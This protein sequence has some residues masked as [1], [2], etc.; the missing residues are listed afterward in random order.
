MK[1]KWMICMAIVTTA[2]VV[3]SAV[4]LAVAQEN[5]STH[6]DEVIATL[7]NC[8][9][10]NR[11]LSVLFLLDE[12]QSL[13]GF[14]RV[15]GTDEGHIRV[16]GVA[17]ALRGLS[18]LQTSLASSEGTGSQ[19]LQISIRIDGFGENYS[20][21]TGGEWEKLS[22][23]SLPALI[24]A[25]EG[26]T[27]RT[28]EI[29]T[30]Y[31]EAMSGAAAAFSQQRGTCKLLLWFTDGIYDSDNSP[32]GTITEAERTEIETTLCNPGGMV[33]SLRSQDVIILALA[34]S[35]GDRAIDTSLVEVMAEGGTRGGYSC[36]ESNQN[37]IFNVASKAEDL[38]NG[39]AGLLTNTVFEAEYEPKTHK[40][41]GCQKEG[42]GVS[43]CVFEFQLGPWT[44]SF[45]LYLEVP[46]DPEFVVIIRQPDGI[47]IPVA[48]LISSPGLSFT[49]PST[50]WRL[51]RGNADRGGQWS[52]WWGLIL[53][54][55][56]SEE[57][58]GHI[59][60][61]YDEIVV[62]SDSSVRLQQFEQETFAA[63]SLLVEIGELP[64]SEATLSEK[65]NIVL[66]VVALPNGPREVLEIADGNEVQPFLPEEF[67]KKVFQLADGPMATLN[68]EVTPK[69]IVGKNGGGFGIEHSYEASFVQFWLYDQIVVELD[70]ASH[71]L[72]KED[73]E[74]LKGVEVSL[75]VGEQSFDYKDA[76][77]SLEFASIGQSGEASQSTTVIVENG[78]L[79]E[80][81]PAFLKKVIAVDGL[82]QLELEVTPTL[83][84]DGASEGADFIELPSS[85]IQIGVRTGPGY[86]V[87]Q[88]VTATDIDQDSS[89]TL[90]VW[91]EGPLDGT[92][93]LEILGI[94]TPDGLGG[95]FFLDSDEI[96]E[97][98]E[99]QV[100]VCDA[101]ISANFETTQEI[102]LLVSLELHGNRA[103][104][105][106]LP[107]E[108]IAVFDMTK[109]INIPV[110]IWKF[111]IFFAIFVLVQLL[112]AAF[113]AKKISHWS[114]MP[115]LSRW[116]SIPVRV[117]AD[118]MVLGRQG[119]RL[120]IP[121]DQAR[122]ANEFEVPNS[123]AEVA[124]V[125][126]RISWWETFIGKNG[127]GLLGI[128]REIITVSAPGSHCFGP[129][130]L[131]FVCPSGVGLIGNSLIQSWAL[132][133][134]HDDLS[135]VGQG[136]SIN[137]DL[138]LLL[139]DH[140]IK[141]FDIQLEEINSKMTIVVEREIPILIEA[142]ANRK[143]LE[144]DEASSEISASSNEDGIGNS[145][146]DAAESNV[147]K[148]DEEPASHRFDSW[149]LSPEDPLD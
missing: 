31:R 132:R 109:P 129:E 43:E 103:E 137:G 23:A 33:S 86:P 100:V 110:A 97:V 106:P 25:A 65:N 61:V 54:G 70:N 30:D 78:Y 99:G 21:G 136:E 96:C 46:P 127:A 83:T 49:A 112:L 128:Q 5:P 67:L 1:K 34:L 41:L 29:H 51:L 16:Q 113:T 89:S 139:V 14:G 32:G 26:F 81:P 9:D 59:D 40:E 114:P 27:S 142:V 38:I 116:V 84:M 75:T 102:E 37:G 149:L 39:F 82:I 71:V 18:G 62:K 145:P 133:I 58:I 117:S 10:E 6:E 141:P 2:L 76:T 107:S 77:L 125:S 146:L 121:A 45:N 115:A 15:K 135:L 119:E 91:V 69:V 148:N 88:R 3:S 55:A 79:V 93:T 48:E 104:G 118:G 53:R 122:F 22:D 52:G 90:S 12:S 94:E 140:A 60:F 130:G 56:G 4:G 7:A 24:E 73:Y 87:V 68:L 120:A 124:G 147:V 108:W 19:E 42:I 143:D 57:A 105:D 101:K 11:H 92:G 80:I 131:R 66:E 126:F 47:E 144:H 36:G 74:S 63:V 20:D 28:R 50:S 13:S 72:D 8:I 85:I 44:E 98:P 64:L 123:S 17:A 134:D 111:L 138:I 95:Q 35:G